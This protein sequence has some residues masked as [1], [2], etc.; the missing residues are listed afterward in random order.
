MAAKKKVTKKKVAKKR[1]TR[2]KKITEASYEINLSRDVAGAPQQTKKTVQAPNPEQAMNLAKQGDPNVYD[3][4]SVKK[5]GGPGGPGKVQPQVTP[6]G[7]PNTL[8]NKGKKKRAKK[9]PVKTYELTSSYTAESFP[10]P[11]NI[12][13]PRIFEPITEKMVAG[14]SLKVKDRYALVE[15]TITNAANMDKVVENLVKSA[16]GRNKKLKTMAE[17]VIKG[18]M[19]GRTK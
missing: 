15:V 12:A 6:P 17:S 9:S 19:H 11:Y 2:K 3:E 7:A 16:K 4:I 10:F 5:Q 14:T 18:I 1:I 13:L 8:E